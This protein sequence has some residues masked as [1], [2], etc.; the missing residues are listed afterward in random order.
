MISIV[1]LGIEVEPILVIT[2]S[3]YDKLIKMTRFKMDESFLE[4]VD[5]S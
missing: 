3:A 4:N 2:E 5:D 1:F